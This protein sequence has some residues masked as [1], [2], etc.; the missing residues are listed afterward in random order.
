MAS[1]THYNIKLCVNTTQT[2]V[3]KDN[4]LLKKNKQLKNKNY[5]MKPYC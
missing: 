4:S 5:V 2:N 3:I 1:K